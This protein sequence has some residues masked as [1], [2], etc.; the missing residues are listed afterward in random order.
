MSDLALIVA[1][2]RGGVI[3]RDNALPWRQKADLQRFK[4]LTMGH[5]IIMGRRTFES[6]GRA[7]PGRENIVLSQT[8]RAGRAAG[9]LMLDSLAAAIGHLAGRKAFVIGGGEIYALALPYAQ[10]VFATFVDCAVDGDTHFPAVD[11]ANWSLTAY[12]THEAD[13]DNQYRMTFMDFARPAPSACAAAA[14]H[15]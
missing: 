15:G 3:G 11:W 5:P 13:E 7:L 4:R 8:V 10:G 12:A 2:G 9:H 1:L 6:I 14:N